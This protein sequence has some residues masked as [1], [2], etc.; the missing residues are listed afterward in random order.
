[1]EKMTLAIRNLS[2]RLDKNE[3]SF[4]DVLRALDKQLVP[5]TGEPAV[6]EDPETAKA[7]ETL[8][9]ATT[10]AFTRQQK[11][12]LQEL[13]F[14]IGRGVAL[15]NYGADFFDKIKSKQ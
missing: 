10:R 1:M 13:L 15:G 12:L 7:L 5:V 2:D 14:N 9:I 8:A 6:S 11:L 4:L 3:V